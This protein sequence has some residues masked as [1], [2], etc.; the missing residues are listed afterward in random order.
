MKALQNFQKPCFGKTSLN[1]WFDDLELQTYFP[2]NTRWKNENLTRLLT[3][4][5]GI[6]FEFNYCAGKAISSGISKFYYSHR[7]I[8]DLNGTFLSEYYLLQRYLQPSFWIFSKESLDDLFF[9][10]LFIGNWRTITLGIPPPKFNSFVYNDIKIFDK[11]YQ[12]AGSAS[13]N[14]FSISSYKYLQ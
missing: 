13:A 6:S 5:N 7:S 11:Y 12:S 1:I 4:S 2:D 9:S 14:V 8:Y 10:L 3:P